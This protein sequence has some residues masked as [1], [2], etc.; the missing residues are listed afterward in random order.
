MI[1]I[2]GQWFARFVAKKYYSPCIYFIISNVK[3]KRLI[4]LSRL[5]L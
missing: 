5:R 3:R 2:K 4:F 1:K